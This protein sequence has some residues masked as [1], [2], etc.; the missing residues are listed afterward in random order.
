[1]T[2]NSNGHEPY[3]SRQPKTNVIAFYIDRNQQCIWSK[4]K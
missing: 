3:V 1:L 4:F 2:V